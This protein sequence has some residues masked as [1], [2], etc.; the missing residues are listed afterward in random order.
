MA[1]ALDSVAT[2][3]QNQIE[4]E[5]Q[6]RTLRMV[7]LSA[8]VVPALQPGGD[9][10]DLT[11]SLHAVRNADPQ[12]LVIDA[13]DRS[14][15]IVASTSADSLPRPS[16]DRIATA[17]NLEGKRYVSASSKS[18]RYGREV[19]Y[20]SV[21]VNDASGQTIGAV[22]TILD[23][24]G[25]LQLIVLATHFN[26]SGY[27]VVIGSDGHIL[28]TGRS[29]VSC[30]SSSETRRRSIRSPGFCSPRSTRARRSAP[31]KSSV[32]SSPPALPSSRSLG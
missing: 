11:S 8:S 32:T 9:L 25:L 30:S 4:Q 14:G 5:V 28:A 19:I 1:V 29:V 16:I 21:P 2:V 18:A 12:Y 24:Q 26:E 7:G 27:A 17:F 6:R 3:I 23:L 20:I 31:F 10:K 22:G 15:Q 13:I